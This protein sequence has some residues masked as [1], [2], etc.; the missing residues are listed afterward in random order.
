MSIGNRN[1]E[2]F[3]YEK[4]KAPEPEPQRVG[5][6]LKEFSSG[7]IILQLVNPD[8]SQVRNG[9]VIQFTMN[10]DGKLRARTML[11]VNRDLVDRDDTSTS[12]RID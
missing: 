6:R 12:I 1:V 2:F 9:N 3:V 4:E 7:R 10:S 5:L 8:G 11:G